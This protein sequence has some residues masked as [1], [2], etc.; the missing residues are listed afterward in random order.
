MVDGRVSI[1]F[2][3]FR[4]WLNYKPLLIMQICCEKL[5][6]KT[7]IFL[8]VEI[9]EKYFMKQKRSWLSRIVYRF[10][11]ALRLISLLRRAREV[12]LTELDCRNFH[13]ISCTVFVYIFLF[14]N[15]DKFSCCHA[16]YDFH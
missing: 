8:P 9:K 10:A 4:W 15:Y 7:E 5:F 3:M 14:Q 1:T 11:K 2:D 6:L 13:I 12:R 16:L